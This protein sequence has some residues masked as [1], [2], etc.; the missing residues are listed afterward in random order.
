M[1]IA[2]QLLIGSLVGGARGGS[3][4]EDHLARVG[5]LLLVKGPVPT[6]T[7]LVELAHGGGVVVESASE[8]QLVFHEALEVDLH[9]FQA[10]GVQ[11]TVQESFIGELVQRAL[12]LKARFHRQVQLCQGQHDLLPDY[13]RG[14][15]EI[16]Q[17]EVI[18]EKSD[19]ALVEG[20]HRAE[21]STNDV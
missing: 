10:V 20:G 3:T 12:G 19:Q 17:Q 16:G 2:A 18:Y 6:V 1:H 9:Q 8:V 11:L 14:V 4:A 21:E 13:G 15:V 7:A 5:L